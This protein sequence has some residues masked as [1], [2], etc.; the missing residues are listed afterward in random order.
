MLFS[1]HNL[2]QILK[3]HHRKKEIYIFIYFTF[4]LFFTKQIKL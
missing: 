1:T 3:M 4:I 2:K